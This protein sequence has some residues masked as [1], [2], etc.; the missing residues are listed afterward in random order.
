MTGEDLLNDLEGKPYN[1]DETLE[2]KT[3]WLA[4]MSA[5]GYMDCTNW[6][7]HDSEEAAKEYLEEMY[8]DD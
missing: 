8:G 3:G 2:R 1:P 4:R 7:V 5:P 6:T